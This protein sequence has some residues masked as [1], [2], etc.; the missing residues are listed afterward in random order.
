MSEKKISSFD[1]CSCFVCLRRH[2]K[3]KKCPSVCRSVCM[4]VRTWTFHVD[5]ITFEG[6]SWFKQN[7]VGVFCMKCRSGIEIQNKILILILI[8]IL[9]RIL[10]LKKTWILN[11]MDISKTRSITFVIDFASGILI[12]ILILKKKSEQILWN[13]TEFHEH[14]QHVKH[15]FVINDYQK[16]YPDPDSDRN[17]TESKNRRK[18]ID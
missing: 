7:F 5:T 10:I 12:L 14:H 3:Q 1:Q 11:F 9:N 4:Y 17:L 2:N 13:K 18:L 8:R 15:N 6:V 16:L